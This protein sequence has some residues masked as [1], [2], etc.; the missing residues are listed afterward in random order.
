MPEVRSWQN[1][2]FG[3]GLVRGYFGVMKYMARL[4][5]F[6][7]GVIALVAFS[8]SRAPDPVPQTTVPSLIKVRWDSEDRS[9]RWT[10]A[11]INAL[12]SHGAPL[13]K[14]VPDDIEQYCPSY[15]SAN[16]RDRKAFWTNLIASLSFHESTW[17]PTVSGGD[18]RWH[19]LLQ[20]S[21]ATAR[22]YGCAAGDAEALKDGAAN[23][24][25]AIRIMAETV[26]RD[27]V[28]SQN[29][30]GIAADWGPFHQERKRSEIQAYTKGL[31]Y[32]R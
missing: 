4:G 22:G 1:I 25:C 27:G 17:R 7:L 10:R 29:M 9:P 5:A 16:D 12:D 24:S 14:M 23:V 28:I 30:R 20:I 2:N 32:C 31:P 15:A 8:C 6:G 21:P 11:A 26:P 13:V 19:G 18:G 3:V